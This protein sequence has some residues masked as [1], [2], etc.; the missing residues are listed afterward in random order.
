[1]AV[2]LATERCPQKAR[3]NRPWDEGTPRPL[4]NFYRTASELQETWLGG[5]NSYTGGTVLNEF[6]RRRILQMIAF[7]MQTI[8]ELVAQDFF[9]IP[10]TDE[11]K[12]TLQTFLSKLLHQCKRAMWVS[13]YG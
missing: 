1:M 11:A 12:P 8:H 5:S 7:E 6:R 13:S 2:L 9:Q 10:P 4:P 3:H